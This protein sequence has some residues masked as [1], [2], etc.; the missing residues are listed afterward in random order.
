[1]ICAK[2][3]KAADEKKPALHKQCIGDCGCQ[4]KP[5]NANLVVAVKDTKK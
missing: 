3:V 4:H 2:C 1:M 5:L